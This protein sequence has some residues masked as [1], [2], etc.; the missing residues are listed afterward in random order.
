MKSEFLRK[1]AKGGIG[2]GCCI[3]AYLLAADAFAVEPA[4]SQGAHYILGNLMLP[5]LKNEKTFDGITLSSYDRFWEKWHLV[6]T[7]FRKDNGE[8]RFVFAN[9]IAYKAIKEGKSVYPDGAMFGKVAFIAGED[10]AFPVSEEPVSFSRVQLMRKDSHAYPDQNGWG[11][12]LYAKGTGVPYGTEKETVNACHACHLI[13]RDRDHVFSKASFLHVADAAKPTTASSSSG[14]RLKSKFTE[15]KVAELSGFAKQA[16]QN[17]NPDKLPEKI[18]YYS[19]PLFSGSVDESIAVLSRYALADHMTYL[20][21]DEDNKFYLAATPLAGNKNCKE[22]TRLAM[23]VKLHN[24]GSKAGNNKTQ[25][26]L[27]LIGETCNGVN[28]WVKTTAF[29]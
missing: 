18:M 28:H 17:A 19:M 7:R 15:R 6:T 2:I 13:V 5:A 10:A 11:Y 1:S 16:V 25:T 4:D 12:A 20:I 9:D 14:E 3:A 24:Q 8:Q 29:H 21:I 26:P 27:L 22:R 23:L